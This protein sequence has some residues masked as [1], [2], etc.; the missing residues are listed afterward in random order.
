MY[1]GAG[2][3]PVLLPELLGT[4]ADSAHPD[5]DMVNCPRLELAAGA[6]SLEWNIAH[7]KAF[8]KTLRRRPLKPN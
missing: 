4:A 7:G 3:L 6:E 1:G 2:G 5:P 8:R